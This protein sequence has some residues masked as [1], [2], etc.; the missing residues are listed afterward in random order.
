MRAAVFLAVVAA[1]LNAGFHFREGDLAPTLYFMTAAIL[2]T[3][4]TSWSV[5]RRVI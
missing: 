2:L 4:L 1:L 3:A 5:R